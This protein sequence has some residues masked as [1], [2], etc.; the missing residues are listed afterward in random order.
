[1]YLCMYCV[2]CTRHTREYESGNDR[3]PYS[4]HTTQI[5]IWVVEDENFR[6]VHIAWHEN[7]NLHM[8]RMS[9]V[10]TSVWEPAPAGL[11]ILSGFPTISIHANKHKLC[12]WNTIA[13]WPCMV[14]LENGVYF[15]V[16][17][18]NMRT[19]DQSHNITIWS[20]IAHEIEKCRSI[21]GYSASQ[22]ILCLTL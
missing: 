21:R 9:Q 4:G 3:T 13:V 19:A 17:R 20:V 22:G 11:K 14:W 15:T 16:E 8:L 12:M 7:F 6:F 5:F 10:R 2:L 18:A 1:M